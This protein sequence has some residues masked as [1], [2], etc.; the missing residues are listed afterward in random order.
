MVVAKA[1][2]PRENLGAGPARRPETRGAEFG[3]NFL[4]GRGEPEG[5]NERTVEPG[6]GHPLARVDHDLLLLCDSG[7]DPRQVA[8]GQSLV[9]P[10]GAYARSHEAALDSDADL[11]TCP[12][13]RSSGFRAREGSEQGNEYEGATCPHEFPIGWA[14][15]DL[16][17]QAPDPP[18]PTESGQNGRG[19]TSIC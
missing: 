6:D 14:C 4:G 13:R 9:G 19:W 3:A 18:Q 5:S 11:S 7:D 15:R 17:P 16:E 2:E 12:G 8:T 10:K 1:E